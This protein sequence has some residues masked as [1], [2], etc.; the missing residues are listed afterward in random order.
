[1]Y[2]EAVS[3]CYCYFCCFCWKW[4]L[5]SQDHILCKIQTMTVLFIRI[6]TQTLLSP[7]YKTTPPSKSVQEEQNTTVGV[8]KMLEIFFHSL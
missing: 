8:V 2:Q 1:M 4:K 6:C 5:C 7:R 3:C